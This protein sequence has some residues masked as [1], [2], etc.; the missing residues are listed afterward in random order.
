MPGYAKGSSDTGLLHTRGKIYASTNLYAGQDAIIT[1]DVTMR[2]FTTQ[3][4]GSREVYQI[5]HTGGA[6]SIGA[7]VN[8][9]SKTYLKVGRYVCGSAADGG[10]ISNNPCKGAFFMEVRNILKSDHSAS[11]LDGT[12]VYHLRT[13]YALGGDIWTQYCSIGGT[14]GSVSYGPWRRIRTD[15]TNQKQ[16]QEA[17]ASRFVV[18]ALNNTTIN[19]VTN[20][21]TSFQLVR[22]ASGASNV[23]VLSSGSSFEHVRVTQAILMSQNVTTGYG[24][25]GLASGSTVYSYW[26][27]TK[28]GAN[29]N[30]NS[31]ATA[32]S[33]TGGYYYT[34][35][36]INAG[37]NKSA[38]VIS[39][40]AIKN[41]TTTGWNLLGQ[42]Q[43]KGSGNAISFRI[44]C[45]AYGNNIV[46]MLFQA[47]PGTFTKH[48]L[49]IEVIE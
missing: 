44:E 10:T 3:D 46:P 39:Y 40:D 49:E 6:T 26:S 45:K 42:I 32:S 31:T 19:M 20:K 8:L 2:N 43:S 28:N 17:V 27:G 1:R 4:G 41:D 48:R 7:N 22:T 13:L 23:L 33:Q 25:W 34:T 18:S 14:A 35:T 47:S 5:L 36:A 29:E 12:W 9:N 30:S 11:E 24:L 37:G 21:S 38:T 15:A 16:D